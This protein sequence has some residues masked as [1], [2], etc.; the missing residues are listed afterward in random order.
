MS[1]LLVIFA[2]AKQNKVTMGKSTHFFRTAGVWSA[3]RSEKFFEGHVD[4]KPANLAAAELI[5]KE[6]E[7]LWPGNDGQKRTHVLLRPA[8]LLQSAR[9][10]PENTA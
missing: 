6:M 7:L 10:R 4:C 5:G 8:D 2:V 3:D 9:C 1:A